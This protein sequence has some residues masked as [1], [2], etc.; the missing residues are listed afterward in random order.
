M[1]AIIQIVRKNPDEIARFFLGWEGLRMQ[2]G[3]SRQRSDVCC[4]AK[5]E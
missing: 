2:N 1:N 4:D 5:A 3:V